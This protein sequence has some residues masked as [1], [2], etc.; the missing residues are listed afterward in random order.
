MLTD[1]IYLWAVLDFPFSAFC[2]CDV[3]FVRAYNVEHHSL[4]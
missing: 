1:W 4:T 3:G 2:L